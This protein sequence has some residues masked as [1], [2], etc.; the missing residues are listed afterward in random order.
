M[1]VL[2]VVALLCTTAT[3]V[4]AAGSSTPE[5]QTVELRAGELT[6]LLGNQADHGAKRLGYIGVWSL[7]SVREPTNV[8]V[9]RYAGLI[10]GR[11][12]ARLIRVSATE[13]RI[14]HIE[15]PDRIGVIQDFRMV[16]PYYI[17]CVFRRNTA[18]PVVAFGTCSYINGPD[19]PGIYFL[20]RDM[21]WQRHYDPKH[22]SAASVLPEGM[23]PPVLT[24][25]PN[26]PYAHG[27]ALFR[28]SISDKRYHPDYALFYGRFRK[29]VLVHMFPPRSLVIP[30]MSPSGGGR[31]TDGRRNP[32]WDWRVQVPVRPGSDT[33]AETR[34]L[35]RLVYKPY[36]DDAEILA[37]YRK[38]VTLLA[39][40]R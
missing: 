24:R 17:D 26:A 20:N 28:D 39:T 22:G 31:Q 25:I 32:A 7:T 11:N 3:I 18:E 35:M 6:G 4:S 30:F 40:S 19:D 21:H 33:N 16:P 15:P 13:G 5:P 2:A 1:I 10:Q 27:T 9:P 37:E 14:E 23:S 12:T 8:F 38:W 29:M 36:K 34:F